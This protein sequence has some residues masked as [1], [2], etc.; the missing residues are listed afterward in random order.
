[1]TGRWGEKPHNQMNKEEEPG[2][3]PLQTMRA[4]VQPHSHTYPSILLYIPTK[5]GRP[6]LTVTNGG[7]YCSKLQEEPIPHRGETLFSLP[8]FSFLSQKKG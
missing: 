1:M 5:E 3:V 7:W 4:L 8:L 2:G 6:R